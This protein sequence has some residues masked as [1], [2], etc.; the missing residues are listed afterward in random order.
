MGLF[1]NPRQQ[2]GKRL[3]GENLR[4]YKDLMSRIMG[5]KS[6]Y[7]GIDNVGDV[8][9]RFGVNSDVSSIYNPA[10]R[11]L[12]T[13]YA[14][15]SKVNAMNTGRSAT[16]EFANLPAQQNYFEQLGNLDTSQAQSTIG[17]QDYIANLLNQ[18]LGKKESFNFGKLGQERGVLGDENSAIGD[19]VDTQSPTSTFDDILAVLGTGADLGN[20]FDQIIRRK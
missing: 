15:Q 9:G 1:D 13:K 10:R 20:T 2:E 7:E 5:L 12:A 19:Y 18:V 16:P 6:Q 17:R 11:N 3:Y 8:Q 14:Q 4:G